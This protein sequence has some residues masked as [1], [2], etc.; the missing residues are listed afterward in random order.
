[1]ISL[2]LSLTGVLMQL[3]TNVIHKRAKFVVVES[4]GMYLTWNNDVQHKLQ[5]FI[6]SNVCALPRQDEDK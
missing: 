1:V 5:R 3:Y 4:I 2:V 6:K